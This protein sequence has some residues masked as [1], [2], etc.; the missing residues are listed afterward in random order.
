M[1]KK[2]FCLIVVILII[3]GLAV[4]F[5][6]YKEYSNKKRYEEIKSSIQ[7]EIKRYLEFSNPYCSSSSGRFVITDETL[8]YQRGMDKQLLLDVDG[9]SYCKVR[10]E[11][12][13]VFENKLA[14][15]T[16]LSCND[17]EDIRYNNLE[18]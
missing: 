16:Y 9:K 10:V 15:D 2:W 1:K 14:W 4:G 3:I 18:G 5:S 7:G 11:V 13:C 17:Y 6:L 8:L 12:S